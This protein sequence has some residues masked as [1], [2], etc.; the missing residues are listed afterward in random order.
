LPLFIFFTII[1]LIRLSSI[2]VKRTQRHTPL[3][4]LN[5]IALDLL[6]WEFCQSWIYLFSSF[7]PFCRYCCLDYPSWTNQMPLPANKQ[8][9]INY[10]MIQQIKEQFH[11]RY[12]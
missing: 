12:L 6:P 3:E 10:K 8:L 4:K 1:K 7:G 5:D 2:I 11:F 9:N